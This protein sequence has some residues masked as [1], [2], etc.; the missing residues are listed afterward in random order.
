MPGQ[1]DQAD[2]ERLSAARLTNSLRRTRSR[3]LS[4]IDGTLPRRKGRVIQSNEGLSLAWLGEAWV[5][6]IVRQSEIICREAEN[7]GLARFLLIADR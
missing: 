5:R 6:L 3:S 2:I 7:P 4:R 1:T